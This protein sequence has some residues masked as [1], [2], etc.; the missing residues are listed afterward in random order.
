MTK[1]IK[2]KLFEDSWKD[3]KFNKD[4]L[5]EACCFFFNLGAIY[6]EDYTN[7]KINHLFENEVDK[8]FLKLYISEKKND[9]KSSN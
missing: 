7:F 3:I 9:K 6:E 1:E 8:K 4:D 5:K 2:Q